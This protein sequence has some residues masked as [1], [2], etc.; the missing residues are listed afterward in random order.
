MINDIGR[1]LFIRQH[2]VRRRP[3]FRILFVR[4]ERVL[5]LFAIRHVTALGHFFRCTYINCLRRNSKQEQYLY[6][7]G[8]NRYIKH[9]NN[10]MNAN[11]HICAE[12][13]SARVGANISA[14]TEA[15]CKKVNPSTLLAIP[16]RGGKLNG[17]I[18]TVMPWWSWCMTLK[19]IAFAQHSQ[20]I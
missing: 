19:S 9:V 5:A 6:S 2:S 15:L 11:Y 4:V 10:D 17:S 1:A 20:S 3:H 12:M 18:E 14:T 13:P 16:F 7:M 8:W